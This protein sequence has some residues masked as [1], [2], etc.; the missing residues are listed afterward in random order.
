MLVRVAKRRT[1]QTWNR[2]GTELGRVHEVTL[3][4]DAGQITQTT[5]LTSEQAILCRDCGIKA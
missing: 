1:G 4:G 2:I 5:P 3:T